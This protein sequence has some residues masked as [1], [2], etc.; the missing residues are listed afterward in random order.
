MLYTKGQIYRW[1][2]A[3]LQIYVYFTQLAIAMSYSYLL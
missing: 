3:P 1:I 2:I